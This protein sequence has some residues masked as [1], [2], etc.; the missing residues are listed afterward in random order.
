MSRKIFLIMFL[1]VLVPRFSV[2]LSQT[3]S[4]A[5]KN[6]ANEIAE[7]QDIWILVDLKNMGIKN[8]GGEPIE[9]VLERALTTEFRVLTDEEIS[10]KNADGT[11]RRSGRWEIG[12]SGKR[13]VYYA[14]NE[15][16]R[17]L[18]SDSRR[19][20]EIH[21]MLGP[22]DRNFANSAYIKLLSKTKGLKGFDP[23]LLEKSLNMENQDQQLKS[24]GTSGVDGGGDY[25]VQFYVD[26]IYFEISQMMDRGQITMD[27]IQHLTCYLADIIDFDIDPR[28]SPGKIRS[29]TQNQPNGLE[30]VKIFFPTPEGFGTRDQEKQEKD[31][32]Q[33]NP[34]IEYLLSIFLMA[35][36]NACFFWGP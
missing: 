6:L 19:G 26:L 30:R 8:I 14:L 34:R 11:V 27:Q 21:E 3:E 7:R 1:S 29:E 2:A 9:K 13:R 20:L 25:R 18:G 22:A 28:L 23:K 35:S 36:P 17:A 32:E 12:P 4:R 33:I 31:Y 5:A 15:A 10:F 24:G 16:R